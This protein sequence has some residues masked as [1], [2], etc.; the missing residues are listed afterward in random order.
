MSKKFYLKGTDEELKFGDMIELDMTEEK[1]GETIH[2]HVECKFLPELVDLLLE[3]DVIEERKPKKKKFKR[4]PDSLNE[5]ELV[6]LIM[7][8]LVSLHEMWDDMD[9]RLSVLEG[10]LADKKKK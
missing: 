8:N 10:K 9:D 2:H 5:E 7:G 4:I 1:K 3:S 6:N